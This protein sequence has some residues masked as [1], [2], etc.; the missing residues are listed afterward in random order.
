MLASKS[1]GELAQKLLSALEANVTVPARLRQEILAVSA[2]NRDQV[3]NIAASIV[4][5]ISLF[6]GAENVLPILN[7]LDVATG[8]ALALVPRDEKLRIENEASLVVA[9]RTAITLASMLPT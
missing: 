3:E 6:A 5:H 8:G 4:R 9:R 1:E 7:K 2:S